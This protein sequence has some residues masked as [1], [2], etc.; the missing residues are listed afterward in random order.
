MYYVDGYNV[1]YH[2]PRLR[3]LALDDIE[4]ARDAFVDKVARYCSSSGE[5]ARI[6]FDGRGRRPSRRPTQCGSPGVE[7][8]YSPEKLSADSMIERMVYNAPNRREII[9]VSADQG[10]RDLCRGMGA[11]VMA[12]QNFL[13]R[14]LAELNDVSQSLQTK[15]MLQERPRLEDHLD[16]KARALLDALRKKLKE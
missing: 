13:D 6:V 3:P 2:S 5:C 14:V 4:A 15:Q 10:I 9:V 8:I 11:L 7:I 1:I 16:E 12:S